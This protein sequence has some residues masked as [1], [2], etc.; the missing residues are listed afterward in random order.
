MMPNTSYTIEPYLDDSCSYNFRLSGHGSSVGS[1]PENASQTPCGRTTSRMPDRCGSRTIAGLA[2][3]LGGAPWL[4][5]RV[6][7]AVAGGWCEGDR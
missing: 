4:V 5:L 1:L 6:V 7:G 2:E 3:A